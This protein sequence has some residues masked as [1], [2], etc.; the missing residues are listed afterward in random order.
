LSTSEFSESLVAIDPW[1]SGEEIPEAQRNKEFL[2][3]VTQLR[4]QGLTDTE[5]AKGMEITR[6]QL[7]DFK[8]IARN[9]MKAEEINTALRLKNKGMSNIEIGKEMGKNESSVRSLLA[10]GQMDKAAKIQS[11]TNMLKG[12]VD[13]HSYIDIGK[14][15][16]NHLG[17]TKD[18][19]RTAVTLLKE[20]GYVEHKVQVDQLGTG[21]NQKTLV[22]VLCKPETTYLDVKN[23]R[24]KIRMINETS[25]DHGLN[26]FGLL[27]PI[28]INPNRISVKYGDEG[29]AEADG[30]IYV[31]PGV[32]DLS[33]GRQHY[34]QVRIAVDGDRYLKG[35][36]I[37]KDDLPDGVDLQFNTNKMN[38]GNKLDA[39]KPMKTISETDKTIDKDNPF[40]STVAQQWIEG[41]NN[42][43]KLTSAMNLVNEEADWEKWNKSLSSQMLSKQKPTLAKTQLDLTYEQKNTQLQRILSLTNPTVKRKLLEEFADSTDSSAIHLKAAH[44]PRQ[45]TQVIIPIK[46]L[47]D[48]E[49]YAPN[50]TAGERVALIR[51]PHGGTFEIPELTVNNRNPEAKKLLGQATMAVGINSNVAKRMSGADFD[52]DTVLVIPN[53]QGNIKSTPALKGL[54]NFDPQRDYPGFEGM[55]VMKSR[56]TQ[57]EMGKISNLIT[58]MTIQKA[59][60]SEIVRAVRHS[61]VVIDAEKHKL[62]YKLSA[63]NNG[64]QQLKKKYQ[65]ENGGAATLLSRKKSQ[66]VVVPERKPT[67][68]VD[69]TTGKKIPIETG[70]SYVD[71]KTGKTVIITQKVNRLAELDD[72]HE[73]SSGTPMEK[74][75]ADHSNRLKALANTARLEA[76]NTPPLVASPSAKKQYAKEVAKLNADLNIALKNA[77]LERR[78][79]LLANAK[80]QAKRDANPGMEKKEIKKLEYQALTEARRRLGAQK[81]KIIISDEGW[82]AI[83]AGAI[84]N[85]KLSEILNNADMD[86]VKELA[87]PKTELLMTNAKQARAQAM[88]AAG[89]PQSE[90]AETLGVS[91]TTLQGGLNG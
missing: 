4:R 57:I 91:L 59:P 73:M 21:G 2:D 42:T 18:K 65:G 47:K 75:Y 27:P 22:K 20:Q 62:N 40:G 88:Y 81:Q 19:L 63:K 46:S 56:T 36:A 7:Q 15:V 71:R 74:I 61:M 5:I 50:F 54:E 16:E 52:G 6:N 70:N 38:T 41:P 28:S 11:I 25:E 30:L 3:Y 1:G 32:S 44:M 48:T 58:D 66:S 14:G 39:M 77:P 60:P 72:A 51:Y 55:N 82:A 84:S 9:Q 26:F 34:A 17:I 33:L 29:G 67:F 10:D 68:R 89:Y 12:Q 80:V 86:R 13:E 87:S 53:G 35:M 79:Q 85:S 76:I 31:R 24:D 23:N 45:Q 37:Y 83:Q 49:I 8:S 78:A 64:I 69:K 90:I 43:R